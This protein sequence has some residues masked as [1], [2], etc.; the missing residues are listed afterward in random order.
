MGTLTVRR[1]PDTGRPAPMPQGEIRLQ[2]PP[3]LP[4]R[5]AD[6]FAQA[7][8]Y[9]PMGAMAIGTIAI[10]AGG[11]ASAILYVGSG[12]M[13]VGMVGMMVGQVMRG[14]GDRKL[15]LNG[16]RR[17]YLRYLSQV[18]E[19]ARR[20]AAAQREVLDYYGPDPASLPSRVL[21]GQLWERT[22]ADA[23][24]L[25]VRCATGT[26]ALAIRLIPPDTKP[27]ED[28]DPLCVGALRRFVHTFSSV[29]RLPVSVRLRSFTSI[30]AEGDA[31]TVR[32]LIR[33]L[34]AQIAVAHSPA[35]VRISVC[36]SSSGIGYWEWIKWLPHN[37]HPT[38]SDG[39]GPVRLMAPSMSSLASMLSA[40]LH[41]RPR[42]SPAAATP[43]LPFHLIIADGV[44]ADPDADLAGVDGV[45]LVDVAGNLALGDPA[46]LGLRVT[47]EQM[48]RGAA[49]L[50]V[51]DML[52]LVA[53]EALA[54]Q[55]APLRPEPSQ[56]RAADDGFTVSTTLTTL[57][58][59]PNPRAVNVTELWRPRAPRDLLRVPIGH[60]DTGAPVELD[61][62]ESA[63]GGM[64]PHGLIIGAT[65]S[66][67]SE[68]L[69]TLVLGLAM[70]HSPEQLNF[71]LV[72][73]KG[74]ATFLGL[75]RLPHV[76]AV[77]TNLADELP[78][79]D[80][81][82]DALD[83]ELVR[84]QE[85]FRQ[86]GNYASL[87]DYT[88]ARVGG[89]PLRPIPSLFVV[90][91]EFS[92]LLAAKPEFIDLFGTIGRVG[93]SLG[94]HLL[95]AS[96]RLD[97]GRLRGLETQL[98][99]RI[100]LRT[101]S[102]QESRIVLGV[103]DA[104]ELPAQPGNA[105]LKVDTSGMTR[106]KA[107]Y[108]SG[109]AIQNDIADRGAGQQRVQPVIAEFGPGYVPPRAAEDAAAA[110]AFPAP[111][112]AAESL[113]DVV[114]AQ[115]AGRGPTAHE[116]WLPPL[117]QP[118]S[119]A[120][121]LSPLAVM[122]RGLSTANGEAQGTLRA[123][124][125]II[126]RPFQQR[127]DPLWTDLSGA[128]GHVG[129]VGAPRSGRS[130]ALRTLVSSLALLHTPTEVQFYVLDF[131][132]GTLSALSGLPHVGG[133]A[134]RAGG[135]QVRRTV[136]ELRALLDQRERSFA[137][138]GIGSIADYRER[139]AAADGFSDVFLVVDGW[140]T[141]RQDYEDL[142]P[143]VTALAARGLG[144]GIHVVAT[145]GKWSEF[146][147]AI[148]DLF[149]TRLELRLGDP[150]ES[151]VGRA[152]AANVPA[153]SPGRGLTRDGLH[154]LIAVPRLDPVSAHDSAAGSPDSPD[155]TRALAAAVAEAWQGPG[156]QPIR[157]L[158][159]VL[160]TAWL[161]PASGAAVPFGIDENALAPVCADFAADPHFLVFGDTEC[162]K[163]NL[164]QVLTAGITGAYSDEH[165]KLIF[166]DYRRSLLD[167]SEVPHQIGYATSSVT[168]SALLGDAR[169]ALLKRLPPPDLS[170]GQLRARSWWSGPDLFVMVDDYE[171]VASSANPLLV[172]SELLPQAR[173]IGLH[174]V[175]ARSAGGAGRAMFEP[176][177]Q[178]MREMGSPGLIMSGSRDEGQLFGGVRPMTLPAGRGYLVER[179]TGS[180]LVQTALHG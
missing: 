180:R 73:F 151:E 64:G 95:L 31:H 144:Y 99:Y 56:G 48:Y 107:A 5:A 142:E 170:P 43:S 110:P 24:F 125:G 52:S 17:D 6:G 105:F 32:D 36:A 108:V 166:I 89:A 159:D 96:Q 9:L 122:P 54:R 93:R 174:V 55:L 128:A 74:G 58:G 102:A 70:T 132:G 20:A 109:P 21:A 111:A 92:E 163:S 80:R 57:L 112:M 42:F 104:Y 131:G 147:P 65:G 23:D 66:G 119:L 130:T 60:D 165:A 175:L 114:V 83:G 41:D 85:L 169:Q 75:E 148:R 137:E 164:L 63:Q 4:E 90:L 61:I 140:L 86:A 136:A 88:A 153:D 103:P 72:D 30:C 126:D 37:M 98:S 28:L 168:A 62:K 178:R 26:Q 145:A 176:V 38:E 123:V 71:V 34:I 134:T 44:A 15:K 7:L 69:R 160:P 100:G 49:S 22:T 167:F 135:D 33:A 106:F 149:G 40:E 2:S 162:G 146:R 138:H 129:V 115:L 68:L 10:V 19:K 39:A 124:L 141:L 121:L 11:H 127:R 77:I 143:D 152:A 117:G 51:P 14:R 13:A 46:P 50:G 94:V 154:F 116:I 113:L 133:V 47:P 101:F 172:L 157:M 171:L 87:R 158:P 150:Y 81:M 97:E 1:T 27:L 161:P 29:P 8:M 16:L 3:E 25:N 156:A 78:L 79:V 120:E 18:R 12:A 35:D 59:V 53:V 173:D 179:R 118:P 84:R 82:R 67:K 91:D 76:S 45:L 177:I 155:A 139:A